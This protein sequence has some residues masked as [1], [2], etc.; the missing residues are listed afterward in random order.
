MKVTIK[1]YEK[2]Y[3]IDLGTDEVTFENYM[4]TI[5]DLSKAIWSEETVNQYW[6]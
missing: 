4:E 6:E 5:K 3:S 1:H 2:T